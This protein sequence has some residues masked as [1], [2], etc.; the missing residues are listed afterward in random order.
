M[1]EILAGVAT[2]YESRRPKL[3]LVAG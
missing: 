3:Q 2:R 1:L